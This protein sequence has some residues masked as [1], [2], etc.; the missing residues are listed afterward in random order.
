MD[1]QCL[2]QFFCC[3]E[4]NII[5]YRFVPKRKCTCNLAKNAIVVLCLSQNVESRHQI[6]R[7]R[8]RERGGGRAIHKALLPF[9]NLCLQILLFYTSNSLSCQISSTNIMIKMTVIQVTKR[10]D[11]YG[12]P[13]S[14]SISLL[15]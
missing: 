15:P 2:F 5:V 13:V 10:R 9:C 4:I 1:V 11:M 8:E 7:E 14:I 12:F 6:I 3:L